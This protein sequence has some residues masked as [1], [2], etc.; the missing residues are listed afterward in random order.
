MKYTLYVVFCFWLIGIQSCSPTQQMSNS[1]LAELYRET[2]RVIKPKCTV[3]HTEEGKSLLYVRLESSN[4]LYVKPEEN[5]GFQSKVKVTYML[6]KSFRY[7]VSDCCRSFLP[8]YI[9]SIT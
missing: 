7:P 9:P 1:N 5:G 2:E 8:E 6:F 3:Y 4:L